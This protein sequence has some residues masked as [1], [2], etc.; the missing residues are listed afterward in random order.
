MMAALT[1]QE[2]TGFL[3]IIDLG[4]NKIVQEVGGYPNPSLGGGLPP[5][6]PSTRPTAR[7]FGFRSFTTSF[8]SL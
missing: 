6:V 8:G 4:T 5:M 3:T 2:F 1:W 7:V